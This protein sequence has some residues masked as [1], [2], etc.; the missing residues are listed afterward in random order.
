M[1]KKKREILVTS[2]LPYANGQ[3]HLGHLVEYIQTDIWVRFQKLNNNSCYYVCADDAHGTAIMLKAKDLNVSPEELIKEVSLDHQQDFAAFNIDFDCYHST[4]SKENQTFSESIF[5]T[6]KKAGYIDQRDIDQAYDEKEN[7]FLPDR[8]IK[9]TCPK[10]KAQNQYGDNCEVCSSTYDSSELIDPVSAVSGEKPIMRPSSH[11]FFDL[12][13]F[14]KFLQNW[15]TSND[16]LQREISNKLNEWFNSGLRPWDITRDAPYFG[17]A[18]PETNGQKFFYVW[19]DAPIGYMASFKK[20]CDEKGLDFSHWWGEKS[21]TELHHFIGKD[22]VYFHALFWPAMLH[23]AGYRLPTKIHAHGFLTINGK[24]MSKSRG[25]FIQAKTYL[26]HLD[27]EYL[28]YYFASKLNG[29]VEDIDL[30]LED[31]ITKV[32]ADLIGKVV[33]IASRCAGFINKRFEGKLTNAID[34]ELISAFQKSRDT[35]EQCYERNDTASAIKTIMLLADKTN[36]Y[37]DTHKPWELA[38]SPENVGKLHESC[39]MGIH[40]FYFL[41][42]YLKPILPCLTSRAESF[43]N[44][45]NLTFSN[46]ENHLEENH[47]INEFTPLLSRIEEISIQRIINDSKQSVKPVNTSYNSHLDKKMDDKKLI[48][49]ED[50]S[51]LDLRLAKIIQAKAVEDSD[52][53]LQLTLDVGELGQKTVFSGIKKWYDPESILGTYTVYV[54]NLQPRK[55]RFGTSEGMVLTAADKK[56]LWLLKPDKD[57]AYAG[58]KIS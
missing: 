50:F 37:I 38:K 3:I 17:F 29:K 48:G 33:N 57:D 45:K 9:G 56:S 28:R 24:K 30:N 49:I 8:Y 41:M 6:L 22:I 31:L 7:L 25:T 58:L 44:V 11:Y 27:P 46:I 21:T 10:C 12:P 55:M 19:L 36:Q 52:K 16:H 32:N 39:S 15:T 26:K 5:L 18:I 42:I 4:H 53:L 14:S 47:K 54:A 51:K 20:L 23:G 34:L 43:L 2:A 1:A 13:K 40:L 35:I